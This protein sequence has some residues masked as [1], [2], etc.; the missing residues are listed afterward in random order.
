MGTLQAIPKPESYVLEWE[1]VQLDGGGTSLMTVRRLLKNTPWLVR[2]NLV[3]TE[4]KVEYNFIAVH[5]AGGLEE[6]N[7]ST[8]DWIVKSPHGKVWFM[9]DSEFR[10]QFTVRAG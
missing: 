3:V 6:W 7:L 8:R 10:S 4:N 1:A 5:G 2:F 9:G